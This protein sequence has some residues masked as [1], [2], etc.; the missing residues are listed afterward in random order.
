MWRNEIN[1]WRING[2]AAISYLMASRQ[3]ISN[4]EKRNNVNNV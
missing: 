1:Q 3:S 2:V 4:N